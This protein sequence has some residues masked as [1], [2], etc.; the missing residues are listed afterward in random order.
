M[1]TTWRVHCIRHRLWFFF[2][3]PGTVVIL[4][5]PWPVQAGRTAEHNTKS[6]NKVWFC[7]WHCTKNKNA[8]TATVLSKL[9]Y[10]TAAWSSA[11][12]LILSHAVTGCATLGYATTGFAGVQMLEP[13]QTTNPKAHVMSKPQTHIELELKSVVS[14]AIMLTAG[15]LCAW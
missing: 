14:R 15:T 11:T 7:F 8:M 5:G 1:N 6:G 12:C 2:F 10:Q 9:V 13:C 4:A 3:L